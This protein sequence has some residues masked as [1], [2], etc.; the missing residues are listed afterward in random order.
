MVLPGAECTARDEG[1]T[2]QEGYPGR[3]IQGDAGGSPHTGNEG[4]KTEE[5]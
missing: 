2:A 1:P 3:V 4:E 5:G